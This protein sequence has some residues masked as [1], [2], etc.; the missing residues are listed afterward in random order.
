MAEQDARVEPAPSEE[1]EAPPP[2][3]LRVTIVTGDRLV[4]EGEA[5]RVVAPA[6]NGQIAI[7][8]GHLTLLAALEPGEMIVRR[9]EEEGGADAAGDGP[10][11]ID[12]AIGGGFL[13]VRDDE[14]IVLADS[15]ERAE[16]IDVARAEEARRRALE[17]MRQYRG[18]PEYAA[19][20]RALSRSR[21]RLKVA[22]HV[23]VR[24]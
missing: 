6:V 18:T 15:A 11:A 14:V 16:E 8:P 2:R 1:E 7:L 10:V 21:A 13:E 5:R 3:T 20:A 9:S 12:L 17:A 23:R 4:Y 22:G 24:R 19:A